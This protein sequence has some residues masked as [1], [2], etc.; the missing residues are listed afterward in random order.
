MIWNYV[1][2]GLWMGLLSGMVAVAAPSP[3][4]KMVKVDKV[5]VEKEKELEDIVV[6]K[7][8]GRVEAVRKV[9]L[10]VRI[11][12]NIVKTCFHE[13]DMVKKGQVLFEIEDTLYK[14]NVQSAEARLRQL[15]AELRYAKNNFSRYEKME[16]KQ[17]V[18]RDTMEN[19][20]S[21]MQSLEAQKIAAEAGLTTALFDLSH[22]KIVAP[23]TGRIGREKYSEGSYVTPTSEPLATIVMM[24]P[25]YVRFPLSER[26]YLL[27]FGNADGLKN[28]A[29][30]NL[31]LAD[32]R[33]Y[34]HSGKVAIGDNTVKSTDTINVWAEFINPDGQLTPGGIVSVILSKS[35]KRKLAGVL[36][37][38][39]MTDEKGNYV[40]VLEEGGNPVRRDVKVGPMQGNYQLIE[41]GVKPGETI[42]IDGTHKVTPGTP[43]E[44]VFNY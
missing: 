11:S 33:I 22:T 39:L 20:L 30:L 28:N 23:L 43:V 6:R 19:S 17:V 36:V 9:D 34:N 2:A 1:K 10:Q 12:G 35:E 7:Y 37:S 26:D 25:I 27:L 31:K 5:L 15:D 24:D 40:Y 13:G 21:A 44:P 3:S 8:T 38:A 14:A 42:I 16:A 32:D 29:V 4:G 41:E 18:S